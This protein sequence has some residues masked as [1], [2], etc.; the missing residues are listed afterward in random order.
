MRKDLWGN[1]VERSASYW[2]FHDESI[3][4]KR[5]LL[6]GLLFVHE[7]HL[8]EATDWLQRGRH[9]ENY[10]HEIHFSELPKSFEGKY[11]AKA[12]VARRW[13]Q[14]YEQGLADIA[15]FTALAVDR[16]SPAFDHKRFTKEFHAYNRF[17]AMAL[18]AGVKWFIGPEELDKVSITFVSDEKDRRSRPDQCWV[19]NFEEYIPYR[20]KVDAFSSQRE[21]KP[22]PHVT[23]NLILKDSATDDLLQL[24]DLLLGATQE[25]IVASAK[26][27]TK[28]E[29]GRL[30]LRWC[31]NLH[32]PPWERKLDMHR[33]FDLWAFPNEKGAPYNRVSFGLPI[34][35][36]QLKLF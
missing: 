31:E 7:N 25:A 5:W 23:M 22:Y 9:A 30:V 3:P 6:I 20:A 2:V 19:D 28:R 11:G 26:R 13:L 35:D 15:R 33:K 32:L 18:K 27:P 34:S 17:T 12:R 24:C 14:A 36:E 21:G 10:Y 4:N 8:K 29:L 1:P 16:H